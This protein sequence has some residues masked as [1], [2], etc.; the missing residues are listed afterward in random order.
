MSKLPII[1]ILFVLN[2]EFRSQYMV[3]TRTNEIDSL[4]PSK[5][6]VDTPLWFCLNKRCKTVTEARRWYGSSGLY[7]LLTGHYRFSKI[8]GS[9]CL[10]FYIYLLHRV[11]AFLGSSE[12]RFTYVGAK[13]GFREIVWL[14]LLY[15]GR[16]PFTKYMI[17]GF[18]C[19]FN[20]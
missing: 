12:H 5:H 4:R 10:H 9:L 16:T 6:V 1:T 15:L 18:Y 17:C 7:L 11:W 8:A 2:C 13:G 14:K 20:Q 3:Q 19:T